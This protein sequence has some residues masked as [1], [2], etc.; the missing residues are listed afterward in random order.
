MSAPLPH[1]VE[2]PSAG[3]PPFLRRL[4]GERLLS[5]ELVPFVRPPSVPSL[6][7][8]LAAMTGVER[9]QDAGQNGMAVASKAFDATLG[10]GRYEHEFARDGLLMAAMVDEFLPLLTEA[11]VLRLAEVQ[12]LQ[13]LQRLDGEPR[14]DLEE[15]G[16]IPHEIRDPEDP[17]AMTTTAQWGWDWPYF[18]SVDATPLF[19]SAVVRAARR[20]PALLAH[21]V[22]QRDGV[23]RSMADCLTAA[24]TWL[25]RRLEDDP[26][27]LLGTRWA[28]NRCWQVWA[29]SPDAYHHAD[30]RL[31]HGNVAA[32]EVQ[33]WAYDALVDVAD[34][35][36]GGVGGLSTIS[37]EAMRKAAVRLQATVIRLFWQDR[38]ASGW[39]AA[40]LERGDDGSVEPLAVR[41]ANMGLLLES[42]LLM[43]TGDRSY[44]EAIVAQLRSP[45][46]LAASGIRTLATTEY[47]YRAS[48]Y[49]NG[50]V[51]PWQNL[52]IA[53][54]LRRHGFGEFAD[55][56]ERRASALVDATGCAP[57]L[58]Q[59]GAEIGVM[60]DAEVMVCSPD[61]HGG[62][63][64]HHAVNV[65]QKF[66]GWT[67]FGLW[68]MEQ[69][70]I[71]QSRPVTAYAAT[72]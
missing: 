59:G 6:D 56:L 34:L 5:V 36:E 2:E 21:S 44:V 66:Q 70:L 32:V 55:D 53:V 46:L 47:R 72:A 37:S 64:T 17:G 30:G 20:N 51:W 58:V 43:G 65:A 27:G 69:R 4:D 25:L 62:T 40:G 57:E 7:Q 15:I 29:D 50:S 39:F 28:S 48:A 1:F 31:A 41:T 19:I 33:A 45:E 35:A 71:L 9:A 11:T 12:G 38:I 10:E 67:A 14:Y 22:T 18:G 54:G 61:G 68:A 16:R 49:H 52:W 13:D 23:D 24:I 63:F 3:F 60:N 8:L 26:H 42:H